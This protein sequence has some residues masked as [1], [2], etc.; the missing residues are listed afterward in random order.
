MLSIEVEQHS[1]PSG[2]LVGYLRL[3]GELDAASYLDLIERARDTAA[4]GA[5]GL[6]LD[7]EGLDY[8]GSSGIFALHSI[9]MLLQGQAPPDPEQGW[10]AMHDA[11]PASDVVGQVKLLNPQPQVERVLERTGMTRFFE[12]HSDRSEAMAAFPTG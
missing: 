10:A 2:I 11:G 3:S 1:A 8:M 9:A 7:L 5:V 6:L 12:V 4:Q